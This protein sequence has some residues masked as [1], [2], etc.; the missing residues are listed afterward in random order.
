MHRRGRGLVPLSATSQKKN[1]NL[2]KINLNLIL[3]LNQVDL[4]VRLEFFKVSAQKE[5]CPSP[6]HVFTL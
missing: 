4:W 2:I 5:L 6:A 3:I 1:F